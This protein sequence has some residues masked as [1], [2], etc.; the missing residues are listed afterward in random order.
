MEDD[1]IVKLYFERDEKAIA[2]TQEKY[3]AYLHKI[4]YNI[5]SDFEDA[6]ESVSDSYLKAW[7][8]IPPSNPQSLSAYMAK[9]VR[10]NSIDIYRKKHSRKRYFCEY[11]QALSE[12]EDDAVADET[13][14]ARV[15]VKLLGEM[16]SE[17]LK[18][19]SEDM[20]NIFVCRYYFCD[21]IKS[22]SEMTGYSEAKIK[23]SL[24]RTRLGL[25]DFL[26]REDVII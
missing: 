13:V 26:R 23:S 16:I 9:I 5:L 18:G 4:A 3:S 12:I 24:H 14:E 22:I 10:Q 21:S 19:I 11:G 20:R 2:Y 17:Y 25:K 7:N 8:S 15:D 1:K 6:A